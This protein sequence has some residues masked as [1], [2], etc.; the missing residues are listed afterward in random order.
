MFEGISIAD[1]FSKIKEI[2]KGMSG[3]RKYYIETIAGKKL[4]LRITDV[5]NYETKK[6][7][8][9]FLLNINKANLPVP[10][11]IDFGMCEAGKSVYMILEW[12]EGNEAEEV[13]PNML[14]ENQYS[15]GVKSG[16]I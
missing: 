12:I 2:E 10:K 14:K 15:L 8:Y 4:L 13:V 7:D 3:D 9:D 6:K 1:T 5:S 11:A 16:Q